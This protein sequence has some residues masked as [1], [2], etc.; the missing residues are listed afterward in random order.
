MLLKIQLD[1]KL[2]SIRSHLILNLDSPYA[3]GGLRRAVW[4]PVLW[5][6][7][8]DMKRQHLY[9]RGARHRHQRRKGSNGSQGRQDRGHLGLPAE[10]GDAGLPGPIGPQGIPG[11]VGPQGLKGNRGERGKKGNRGAKG[12][13]GDQGAPGLDAPCPLVSCMLRRPASSRW[14]AVEI[15]SLSS[16]RGQPPLCCTEAAELALNGEKGEPG[17]PGLDGLDAPCPV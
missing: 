10:K 1:V 13:K 4:P 6:Y 7:V 11:L 14:T 8:K 9:S 16:S 17:S 5:E 3:A 12:E 15:S 2:S